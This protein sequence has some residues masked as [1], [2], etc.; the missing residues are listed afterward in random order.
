[1]RIPQDASGLI[2]HRSRKVYEEV[3][4]SLDEATRERVDRWHD[5]AR[6]HGRCISR[7]VGEPCRP[8]GDFVADSLLTESHL[9]RAAFGE[10][11]KEVGLQEA[12]G[13]DFSAVTARFAR[14]GSKAEAPP[15]VYVLQ[16]LIRPYRLLKSAT[17]LLGLD[18][19]G[20]PDPVE[21]WYNFR[22][23]WKDATLEEQRIVLCSTRLSFGESCFAF[24][25]ETPDK[26][27]RA[28]TNL[29]ELYAR[30]GL[31]WP[32]MNSTTLP[33]ALLVHYYWKNVTDIRVPTI[34]DAGWHPCFVPALA[35]AKSGRTVDRRSR[36]ADPTETGLSEVVH[37]PR[38]L[39]CILDRS[40]AIFAQLTI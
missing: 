6:Q 27:G 25:I 38:D 36:A 4:G 37:E 30:L 1:M 7:V 18:E 34:A 21:E 39:E 5:R 8:E 3:Y 22:E 24:Y 33:V 26:G 2:G 13:R 31:D 12:V 11:L 29:D 32:E 10:L 40:F 28:A 16:R 23:R 14:Q 35:Q 15:G 9:E 17:E 19:P 20:G